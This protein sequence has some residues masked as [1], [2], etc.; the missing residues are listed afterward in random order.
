MKISSDFA[1]LMLKSY[2]VR[3]NWRHCMNY[4]AGVEADNPHYFD[5]TGEEGIAIHPLL[6]A[7]LTWPLIQNIADYLDAPG[8]PKEIFLTQ[9]HY[10]EHIEIRRQIIPGETLIINGE[11]AAIL[12]HRAG[13]HGII[14]FDALDSAG[15]PV[16]REYIGAMFRGVECVDE[17]AGAHNIPVKS[18]PENLTSTKTRTRKIDPLRPFIYDACSNIVF[19]IHTSEKFARQVGLPG[20][21]LQG[22]ATLAY[23]IN[24]VIARHCGGD[25][26]M[27]SSLGCRFTGMVLP[28]TDITI[29]LYEKRSEPEMVYF[30]VLNSHSK[31]AISGGYAEKIT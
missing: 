10:T 29:S 30:E 2:S 19:P 7:A 5:D 28:G 16:F 1:G 22:T 3:T 25:P 14:R 4:A 8:F 27:I 24:E 21:I 15:E 23:A 11:F 6:P 31:K 12:P 17:G 13:T 20:I 18:I 9:V 26:R